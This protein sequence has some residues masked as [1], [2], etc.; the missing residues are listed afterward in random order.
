MKLHNTKFYCCYSF[1]LDYDVFNT[2]CVEAPNTILSIEDYC[3]IEGIKY[4]KS[5]GSKIR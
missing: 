1:K 2:Q 4:C 3:R 5:C